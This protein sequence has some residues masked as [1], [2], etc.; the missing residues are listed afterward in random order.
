MCDIFQQ[1]SFISFWF[2]Y[3]IPH[4]NN[5]FIR[6]QCGGIKTWKWNSHPATEVI[7]FIIN[8]VNSYKL[9]LLC[10]YYLHCYAV[11][12]EIHLKV[13][14]KSGQLSFSLSFPYYITVMYAVLAGEEFV[15][16]RSHSGR[17]YI[18][19]HR[20]GHHQPN[21]QDLQHGQ[22]THTLRASTVS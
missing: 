4:V 14:V 13:S 8:E 5:Y 3:Y 10:D 11:W 17:I 2:E 20:R 7:I 15:L 21:L 19:R 6:P 1:F 22:G 9:F 18:C 12:K 16:L